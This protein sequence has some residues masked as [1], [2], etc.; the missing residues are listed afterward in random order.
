LGFDRKFCETVGQ[1][2]TCKSLTL[3]VNESLVNLGLSVFRLEAPDFKSGVVDI[4]ETAYKQH[5][6]FLCQD[7]LS[8]C[9][10]QERKIQ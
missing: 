8:L 5:N 7:F 4:L 2:I 3:A 9:S 1:F 6:L 10:F